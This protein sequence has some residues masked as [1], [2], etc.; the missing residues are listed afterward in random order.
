M[1][2]LFDD[3]FSGLDGQTARTV[4]GNLFGESGLLRQWNTTTVLATQSGINSK[5]LSNMPANRLVVDFLPSADHIICLNNNGKISEQGTFSDL[6]NTDGYVYSLLRDRARGGEASTLATD[7]IKE[8]ASKK[9]QAPPKQQAD[10]EDMRRQRGDSTVYRYYF[11]STGG[12]FMVVLL[13]LEIIWAFLESF[14]SLS[15]SF[16]LLFEIL[17]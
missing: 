17:T 6:K 12:L 15:P 1:I 13:V 4:F 8:Q 7:N 5:Y 3:V 9:A 16:R 2:A 14:P 11:S 10:E